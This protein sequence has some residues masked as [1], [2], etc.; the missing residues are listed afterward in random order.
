MRIN[1][2]RK[3]EVRSQGLKCQTKEFEFYL[4]KQTNKTNSDVETFEQSE[5]RLCLTINKLVNCVK[6]RLDLEDLVRDRS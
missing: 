2:E 5:E 3:F 4:N 6:G 1:L